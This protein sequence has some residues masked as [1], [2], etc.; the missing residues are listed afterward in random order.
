MRV[1]G[2]FEADVYSQLV[3]SG[4]DFNGKRVLDIGTRDGFNCLAMKRLGAAAVVG[5]D[6]D[7]THFDSLTDD[8]TAAITLIKVDLLEYEPREPFDVVTCFLWNMPVPQYDVVAQKIKA[9][10]RPGGTVFIGIHDEIYK[11]GYVDRY[12]KHAVPRTGSVIEFMQTH[13]TYKCI[14]KSAYQWIL[15]GN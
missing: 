9:L 8:D 5:I 14:L 11:T 13:F 6:L 7:D 2:A 12:T 1:S 10:L 15:V 3:R 4:F